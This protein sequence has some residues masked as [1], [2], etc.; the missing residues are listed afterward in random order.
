[1]RIVI[2]T[3]IAFSGILNTNSKIAKIILQPGSKLNLY[4][5]DL[6]L[7]E[8]DEHRAK[9]KQLTNCTDFELTQTITF[10]TSKIRFIDAKLIPSEIYN[11]ALKLTEDIDIDDTEFVALTEHIKAKLWS[12]DKILMNGL[13]R[14]GWNKTIT[15]DE[16]FK[17]I[18]KRKSK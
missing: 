10:L 6:L 1:M 17:I 14:K 9:L 4:A 3:N 7:Q 13:K 16:L 2:D 15:T 8:I 5:T 12:G 11:K 18:L